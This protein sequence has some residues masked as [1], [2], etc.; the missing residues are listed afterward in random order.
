MN[1]MVYFSDNQRRSTYLLLGNVSLADMIIGVSIMFGVSIENPMSC[2]PL[3]IFQIGNNQIFAL[4]ST[5]FIL[6][7]T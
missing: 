7:L 6:K 5:A 2:N 3:C 1:K 4:P